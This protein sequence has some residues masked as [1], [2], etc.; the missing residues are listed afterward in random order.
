VERSL[1]KGRI[2]LFLIV[3][4]PKNSVKTIAKIPKSVSCKLQWRRAVA[5][6]EAVVR[7]Q[8]VLSDSFNV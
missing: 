1:L 5:G 4:I 2:V 6:L 3:R 7:L 8:N